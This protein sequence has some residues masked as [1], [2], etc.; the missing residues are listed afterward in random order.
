MQCIPNEDNM[1]NKEELK[2]CISD[3][4][5]G[6][7]SR[8]GERDEARQTASHPSIAEVELRCEAMS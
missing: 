2:K 7:D 6:Q 1:R 5:E 3:G 8:Q 4:P